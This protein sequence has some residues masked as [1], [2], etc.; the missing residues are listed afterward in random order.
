M[1]SEERITQF[2]MFFKKNYGQEIG[3]AEARALANDFF[4]YTVS[5]AQPIPEAY[6]RQLQEQQQDTGNL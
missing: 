2:Q 4:Q 6:Y 1:L 3:L 5:I